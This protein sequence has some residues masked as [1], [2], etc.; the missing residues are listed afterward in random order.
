MYLPK[1]KTE[2]TE[3][4]T[5]ET[6]I[7]TAEKLAMELYGCMNSA[8]LDYGDYTVAVWDHCF[9]G[10]IA[11]VYELVETP[12]E[13]GFGRCECRISR[14]GRKEGFE[15]ARACNGMGTHKCKIAE[16]AGK[17]FPACVHLHNVPTVSL[18]TLWH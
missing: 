14:I 5:M 10:S 16:R 9:K 3:E 7:T 4:D 2:K 13:T 6:K 12:D 18:C 17:T 11:E 15:N 8:V 1:E